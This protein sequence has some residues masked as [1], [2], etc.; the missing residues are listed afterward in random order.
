MLYE[1]QGT[2][3]PEYLKQGMRNPLERVDVARPLEM[4]ETKGHKVVVPQTS[5]NVSIPY[6]ST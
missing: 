2:K 1:R 5:K 6:Y 3:E 4:R